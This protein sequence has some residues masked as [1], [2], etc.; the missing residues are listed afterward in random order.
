MNFRA[1]LH[2]HTNCSDGTNTPVEL[3]HLAK[4]AGLAGLSITDHD[5]VA[6]YTD[7]VI[8]LAKTLELELLVGVEFSTLLHSSSVHILGYGVD[9]ENPRLHKFC[10]EH[11]E[12]RYERNLRIIEN[13]RKNGLYVCEED[14]YPTPASRKES[15]GR[16][17]IAQILV[18]MGHVKSIE[19]AFTQ[20]IGDGKSCYAQ[21]QPFTVEETIEL[22]HV[23]GGKAFLAHPH[24]IKRNKLIKE[25]LSFPFDGIEC[26]YSRHCPEGERKWVEVA[27]SKGWLISGGSDYHGE[28]RPHIPLGA[29]WVDQETY[30]QIKLWSRMK[31]H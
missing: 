17:H 1:D 29:S 31:A 19:A 8:A 3:L 24:V 14:L 15:K 28:I 12:Q 5:T 30:N 21:G 9:L 11:S 26:Y 6:A 25:L 18:N 20:Y 16:P 7:E 23:C 10:A 4:E 2:T 27:R 22:I 13:L